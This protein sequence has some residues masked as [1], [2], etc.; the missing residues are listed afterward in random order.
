[1]RQ[2]IK[3][4]MDTKISLIIPVYNAEKYLRKLFDS[5]LAQKYENYEIIVIDDGSNDGSLN[6]LKEYARRCHNI[7]IKSIENSGPGIA[8]KTGYELS[9]GDLLFFIDSDDRLLRNDV[10]L[11]INKLYTKYNFDILF[12]NYVRKTEND[13]YITNAFFE[14]KKNSAFGNVKDMENSHI[15]SALWCKVFVRDKMRREYFIDANN[16]EDCYTTY[17]YLSNCTNYYFC[18]D[19]FYYADRSI[20][21]SLSKGDSL[22]K[23]TS[24]TK[25]LLRLYDETT[26]KRSLAIA[27]IEYYLFARRVVDECG[28]TRAEKEKKVKQ[29]GDLRKILKEQGVFRINVGLKMKL[30]YVYYSMKGFLI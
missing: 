27:I 4:E 13:E 12:F 20:Q 18:D 24:T 5:I 6:I 7:K 1:M 23:I 22:N 30:K 10:L 15:A 11:K 21:D 14:S 9:S 28:K 19:V 8:R 17:R 26:L 29:L 25:L 3:K 16:F 2:K